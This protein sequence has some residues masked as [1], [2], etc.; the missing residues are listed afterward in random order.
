MNMM[1]NDEKGKCVLLQ[2]RFSC[3]CFPFSLKTKQSNQILCIP[4][5]C[6]RMVLKPD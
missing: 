1:M 4:T 5:E 6:R 3:F 2:S